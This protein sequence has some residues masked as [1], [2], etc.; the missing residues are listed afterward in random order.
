MNNFKL[1]NL[2][3][4]MKNHLQIPLFLS[5]MM[6]FSG[7]LNFI[8]LIVA[9]RGR[10]DFLAEIVGRAAGTVLPGFFSPIQVHD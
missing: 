1:V 10:S 2:T 9:A 8:T 7:G 4:T 6:N 3:H 5:K